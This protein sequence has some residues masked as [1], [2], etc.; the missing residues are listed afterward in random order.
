MKNISRQGSLQAKGICV[1]CDQKKICYFASF[2]EEVLFCEEYGFQEWSDRKFR[3]SGVGQMDVSGFNIRR[4][5][6]G[7][8]S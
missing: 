1:N 3:H 5:I 7:W 8:E 6:P 2:G 4:L